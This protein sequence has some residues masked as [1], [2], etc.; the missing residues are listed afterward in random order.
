MEITKKN[1]A[2][3]WK[4]AKVALRHVTNVKQLSNGVLSLDNYF[5]QNKF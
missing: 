4:Y 1:R 3:T 5:M 2:K